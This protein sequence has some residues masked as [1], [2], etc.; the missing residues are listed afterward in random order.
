MRLF[1]EF[2]Y[3]F[4]AIICMIVVWTYN[5]CLAGTDSWSIADD[6]CIYDVLMLFSQIINSN[7]LLR[8]IIFQVYQ[9]TASSFEGLLKQSQDADP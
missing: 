8:Q 2:F 6:I 7:L 3:K 1:V 9:L 5:L 4:V